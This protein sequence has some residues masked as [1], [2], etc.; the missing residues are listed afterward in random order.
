[1]Y[2]KKNETIYLIVSV[3]GFLIFSISF[4]LM[5]VKTKGAEQGPNVVTLVAG[6]MFWIGLLVGAIAQICLS[7]SR[8]NWFNKNRVCLPLS[9][10]PKLGVI[11]FF[12]NRTA[13]VFDVLLIIALVGLIVS[14]ILTN[15]TGYACYIF[16][17]LT[18]FSFCSHC[19]FNGKNY[20][21]IENKGSI[22]KAIEKS[23]AD[24]TK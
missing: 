12:R 2:T 14:V 8:K 7:V 18:A 5:I 21:F 6:V 23:K 4:L 13:I 24:A 15:A 20:Y 22:K 3:I 17:A 16:L 1:M 10:Q 19:I 11:T 9:N